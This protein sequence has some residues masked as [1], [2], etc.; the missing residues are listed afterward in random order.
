MH[1]T[2]WTTA[3]HK[4]EVRLCF[5][6]IPNASEGM[7]VR[8]HLDPNFDV[9]L[10]VRRMEGYSPSD[11]CK[12]IQATALYPLREAQEEAIDGNSGG[13][14]DDIFG[15][16]GMAAV[17][18]MAKVRTTAT[19][20]TVVVTS[21]MVVRTTVVTAAAMANLHLEPTI[22]TLTTIIVIVA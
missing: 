20:A 14:D 10:L 16:L 18:V 15:D 8:G 9:D 22:H 2:P 4:L 13:G 6:G 12:V 7:L 17:L 5:T 3:L 19:M 1:P 11:I 21:V